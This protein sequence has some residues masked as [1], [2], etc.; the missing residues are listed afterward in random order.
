MLD[1]VALFFFVP[2]LSRFLLALNWN[3]LNAIN[4]VALSNLELVAPLALTRKA[5]IAMLGVWGNNTHACWWKQY[6]MNH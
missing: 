5:N 2:R 4:N 3:Y 6:G 1:V